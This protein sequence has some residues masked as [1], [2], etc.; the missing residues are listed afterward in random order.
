MFLEMIYT[1]WSIY[2]ST[3]NVDPAN[4]FGGTWTA[5][6]N[7]FMYCVNPDGASSGITGG[8]K[9]I[10]VDNLPPHN[11]TINFQGWCNV[12]SGSSKQCINRTKISTDTPET[13]PLTSSNTGQ[14][15]PYMPPFYTV[16]AWTRTA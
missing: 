16:F 8:S 11:H 14:G 4:I 6:V 12:D 10:T 2:T 9:F 3:R 13:G 15:E 5:I 1:I 7:S